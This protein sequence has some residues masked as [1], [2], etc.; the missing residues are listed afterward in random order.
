[1]RQLDYFF[2]LK[3]LSCLLILCFGQSNFT[4]YKK[5][6]TLKKVVEQY[7]N[8]HAY[9]KRPREPLNLYIGFLCVTVQ[10]SKGEQVLQRAGPFAVTL[11]NIFVITAVTQ[12]LENYNLIALSFFFL[13]IVSGPLY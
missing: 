9:E 6:V 7:G 13:K 3:L 12:N 5:S 4:G 1:M 10:N 11:S 2:C 8:L